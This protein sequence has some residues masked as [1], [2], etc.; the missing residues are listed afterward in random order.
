MNILGVRVAQSSSFVYGVYDRHVP[1]DTNAQ[2]EFHYY[3][4]GA[5]AL[6]YRK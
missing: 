6:V 5:I 1:R 2:V 4:D 3:G